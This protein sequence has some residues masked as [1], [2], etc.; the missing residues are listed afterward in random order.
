M[1]KGEGNKKCRNDGRKREDENLRE[2][3]RKMDI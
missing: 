2:E 1:I 3:N